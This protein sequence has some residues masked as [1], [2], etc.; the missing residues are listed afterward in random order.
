MRVPNFAALEKQRQ[1]G[2]RGCHSYAQGM[3]PNL[4]FYKY[5]WWVFHTDSPCDGQ[6][7]LT[8]AYRLPTAAAFELMER[9]HQAREPYWLYNQQVPRWDPPT[10]PWDPESPCWQGVTWAPAYDQDTDPAHQGHK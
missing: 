10:T 1:E 2:D 3:H 9:L 5:Y 8:E 4:L 7:L 6:A